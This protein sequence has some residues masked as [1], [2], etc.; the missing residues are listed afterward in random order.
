[1]IH[2]VKGTDD[3]HHD[4][5]E[6]YIVPAKRGRHVGRKFAQEIFSRY[7][8]NWQVKQIDG[9]DKAVVFWQKTISEFTNNNYSEESINDSYWGKI[10][11]QRFES[12]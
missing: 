5:A 11:R 9:A 10:T 7:K 6:F 2:V 1:M 12:K 8:G 4:I 3:H